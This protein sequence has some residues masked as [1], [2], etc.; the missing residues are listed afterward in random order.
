MKL[1]K[2]LQHVSSSKADSNPTSSRNGE[3]KDISKFIS[4]FEEQKHHIQTLIEEKSPKWREDHTIFW[5]GTNC[6]TGLTLASIRQ[7]SRCI[8]DLGDTEILN[9][10]QRRIS[11]IVLFRLKEQIKE[12]IKCLIKKLPKGTTYQSLAI[13]I[14][15]ESTCESDVTQDERLKIT[16]KT[17]RMM[18]IGERYTQLRDDI[19][20]K[21]GKLPVALM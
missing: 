21:L 10:M 11:L 19:L 9:S 4:I 8:D 13:S 7:L 5:K 15:V 16:E 6:S 1:R 17:N 12:R 20:L 14:I 2:I 3:T 18:R